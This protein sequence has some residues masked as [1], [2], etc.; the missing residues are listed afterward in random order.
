MVLQ[1]G[2]FENQFITMERACNMIQWRYTR[3][4]RVADMYV[5]PHSHAK[6]REAPGISTK[7]K[8]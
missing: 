8:E 3:A 4:S 7:L 6:E 2:A 1:I 5:L